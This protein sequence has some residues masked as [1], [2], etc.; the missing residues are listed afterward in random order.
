[1][2]LTDGATF[3]MPLIKFAKTRVNKKI[4]FPRGTKQR[5]QEITINNGWN[6]QI[7]HILRDKRDEKFLFKGKFLS[8][9]PKL[10]N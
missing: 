3:P 6:T 7:V 2:N 5:I 8:R 9:P 10:L 1:M 4:I